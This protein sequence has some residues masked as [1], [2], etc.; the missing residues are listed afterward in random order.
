MDIAEPAAAVLLINETVRLLS[1]A[2]GLFT[3]AQKHARLALL[4][5][6]A[7]PRAL[8]RALLRGEVN[9]GTT[10]RV[11]GYLS[12]YA[13]LVRPISYLNVQLDAELMVSMAERH[14]LTGGVGLVM[15]NRAAQNPISTL[16]KFT[17]GGC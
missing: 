7:T 3:T 4:Q 16:P 11:D 14:G 10:V 2:R 8:Q 6:F 9:L 17:I 12:R 5:R 15:A 13:H 1:A